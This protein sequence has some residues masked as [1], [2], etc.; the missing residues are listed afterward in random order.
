[1]VAISQALDLP[2]EECSRLWSDTFSLRNTGGFPD[3]AA[4]VRHICSMLGREPDP[5][6]V[7]AAVAHRMDLTRAAMQLRHDAVATVAQL[8]AAGFRL[9]LVSNCTPEVPGL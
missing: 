4:N 5:V 2:V 6:T 3:I 7:A 1:M 9:G 8:K